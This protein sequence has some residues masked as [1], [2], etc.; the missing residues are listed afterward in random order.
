MKNLI[1]NTISAFAFSTMI[2]FSTF[3]GDKEVKQATSFATS[4]YTSKSFKINV[5][6]DKYNDAST[7][8]LLRDQSGNV[9]YREVV[10]K[11]EKKFR[12]ALDVSQLPSGTYH[13]HIAS[14]GEKVS[15]TFEL[16]EKSEQ[17]IVSID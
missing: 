3:A 9:V 13:L 5:N 11:N 6:V 16:T 4:V 2:A 7:A 15:K 17:R 12:R 8:L 14:N 10:G 1:K